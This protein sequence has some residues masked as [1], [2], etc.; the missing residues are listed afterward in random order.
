MTKNNSV[1]FASVVIAI[2]MAGACLFGLAGDVYSTDELKNGFLTNDVVTLVIGVPM[3]LASAWYAW[4]GHL[5]GR[6]FL[7]GALFFAVYNYIPYI[8]AVPIQTEVLLYMALAVLSAYTV[9]AALITIDAQ[10]VKAEL[11]GHLP[12]RFVG[13]VLFVLGI[14]YLFLV[15][16]QMLNPDVAITKPEI[17]V[18]V[19]DFAM[20]PAWI[21]GGG[22]LWRRTAWGYVFGVGLLFQAVML[23]LAV[24]LVMILQPV[25]TDQ[26][27]PIGDIIVILVMGMFCFVPFGLFMREKV[28][29]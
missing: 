13:G 19:A 24:F 18:L 3:L 23:F 16:G 10:A 17:G 4:R 28:K 27:Y 6:V 20:M 14:L 7:P 21:I 2:L 26:S 25:F 5:L 12:E 22:M 15:V 9:A 1:S 8:Y 11:Q 29:M